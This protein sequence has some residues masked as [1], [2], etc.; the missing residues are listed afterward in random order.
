VW[1][2]SDEALHV[3]G[4]VF[5]AVGDEITHYLPW[6]LGRAIKAPKGPR[7]WDPN[8]I[9]LQVASGIFGTRPGGLQM[10]GG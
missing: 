7:R 6:S 10:G 8:E 1:L 2:A 9:G 5:K 4:Q 3:S